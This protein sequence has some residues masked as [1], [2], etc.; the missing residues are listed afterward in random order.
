MVYVCGGFD[1]TVR[2]TSMERYDPQI[3]EWCMLG[4]MS[5]GRE[6]AGL[7]QANDVMY[8]LGKMEYSSLIKFLSEHHLVGVFHDIN[9]ISFI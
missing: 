8:C 7:V 4:N 6:G 5:I 2:H 1:G 3:D 9:K